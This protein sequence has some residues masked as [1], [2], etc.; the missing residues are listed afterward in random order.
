[1]S[2][3]IYNVVPTSSQKNKSSTALGLTARSP[4]PQG[5]KPCKS[6]SWE[7]G[8]PTEPKGS[9]LLQRGIPRVLL[10]FSKGTSPLCSPANPTPHHTTVFSFLG[11]SLWHPHL[12]HN[13]GE[14]LEPG[15]GR[16][17]NSPRLWRLLVVVFTSLFHGQNTEE[18][19]REQLQWIISS[20][21]V[22]IE[23]FGAVFD[24][25]DEPVQT[26]L[27]ICSGT[28][29]PS[30]STELLSLNIVVHAGHKEI[31]HWTS[32][33]LHLGGLNQYFPV[34]TSNPSCVLWFQVTRGTCQLGSMSAA[35]Q[36]CFLQTRVGSKA[37]SSSG[38]P[39][40]PELVTAT[41]LHSLICPSCPH[42]WDVQGL[43]LL[44]LCR[45]WELWGVSY[46]WGT[47]KASARSCH[48]P[49]TEL[50]L[51]AVTTS[52]PVLSYLSW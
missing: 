23:Q 37:F 50:F 33:F 17:T 38:P 24:G 52:C 30:K 18:S 46:I 7:A 6:C 11:V 20:W 42:T 51:Q 10:L 41:A 36:G 26:L 44:P 16:D 28:G 2:M 5:D 1:M 12:C 9:A 39:I 45:C 48:F 32:V 8:K 22:V 49:R 21:H 27:L 14:T 47:E 4:Q 35:S 13:Q 31:P 19:W 3:F 15:H 29:P 43:V 34:L 25:W 40:I